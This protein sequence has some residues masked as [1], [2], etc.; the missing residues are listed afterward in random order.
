MNEIDR[1]HAMAHDAVVEYEAEMRAGG[2][3]VYPHWADDI[4]K[5]CKQA[6]SAPPIPSFIDNVYAIRPRA[7]MPRAHAEGNR[8]GRNAIPVRSSVP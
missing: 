1:L 6:E 3:P 2:E 8:E 7:A 4:L 5:V